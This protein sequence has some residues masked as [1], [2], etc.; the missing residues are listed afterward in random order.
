MTRRYF[1]PLCSE[2]ESYR[3]LPSARPENLP[4]AR[5]LADEILCL[6]LYGELGEAAVLRCAETLLGLRE[7]APELRRTLARRKD[8]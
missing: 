8:V 3:Q 4:E 2:N 7:A 1:F 5:R 6:P